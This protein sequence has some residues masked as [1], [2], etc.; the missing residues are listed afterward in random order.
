MVRINNNPYLNDEEWMRYHYV[1]LRK[2]SRQIGQEIGV[3]YRTVLNRIRKYGIQK[4]K[5][6]HKLPL[7][8]I[9]HCGYCGKYKKMDVNYYKRNRSKSAAVNYCDRNC[10][11]EHY[12]TRLLGEN[13]P[14]WRHGRATV[15]LYLRGCI[16]EWRDKVMKE[17]NGSCVITGSTEDVEVHHVTPFYKIRDE[18]FRETG[19]LVKEK[20]SEYSEE[21]LR[22]MSDYMKKAHEEVMG[23]P[24]KRNLHKYFHRSYGH[25]TD[26]FDLIKFIKNIKTEREEGKIGERINRIN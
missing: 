15:S 23:V 5:P 17:Y 3:P 26:L 8:V 11:D 2:T 16:G 9:T 12:R 7:Y 22:E 14:N 13:N 4:D 24:I 21:E 6:Y 10:Q 20:V 18:M 19:I 1:T 25:D